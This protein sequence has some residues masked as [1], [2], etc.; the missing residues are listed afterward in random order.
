MSF[1][2]TE[3]NEDLTKTTGEHETGGGDIEPIAKNTTV[4]FAPDEAKYDDYEGDRYISIRWCI[5]KGDHKGRKI[6]QKLRVFDEDK[7]KAGKHKKMFA[8]I[9]KNAGGSLLKLQHEPTDSDLQSILMKPMAGVLQVWELETE[10]GETKTGNWIS[11]INPV[12]S[13]QK[14]APAVVAEEK[15]FDFDS[16]I[17]F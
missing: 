9:A 10:T 5:L 4:V 8:A 14:V 16:D 1:W 6:F 12:N 17:P 13:P 15:A 7:T 2:I 11:S 3:E